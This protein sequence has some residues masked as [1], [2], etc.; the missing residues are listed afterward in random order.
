MS[1]EMA[2]KHE[3]TIPRCSTLG[4]VVM[5]YV[6]HLCAS[7]PAFDGQIAILDHWDQTFD[8]M[9][10]LEASAGEVGLRTRAFIDFEQAMHGLWNAELKPELA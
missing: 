6:Q 9:Q 10:F 8:R 2:P 3:R 5:R 7:M 4:P 1:F